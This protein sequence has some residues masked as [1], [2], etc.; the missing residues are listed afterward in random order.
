[1][2]Q[3]DHREEDNRFRLEQHIGTVLQV[4]VLGLLSWSLSTTVELRT[5]VGVMKAKVEGLQTTLAQ[6]TQ[7]RYRGVDAAR[8]FKSMWDEHYRLEARVARLEGNGKK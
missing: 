6:G 3:Q 1:M 4:L 2:T 7:D 5:D 8:D